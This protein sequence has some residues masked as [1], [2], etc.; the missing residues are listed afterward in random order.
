MQ[1]AVATVRKEKNHSKKD[2]ID[3][4]NMSVPLSLFI[5]YVDA[6][7]VAAHYDVERLYLEWLCSNS[8]VAQGP[9][10]KEPI[11][12]WLAAF[13]TIDPLHLRKSVPT[14]I[15][16]EIADKN[17]LTLLL[18]NDEKAVATG[19]PK[20]DLMEQ[21]KDDIIQVQILLYDCV[22]KLPAAKVCV[23]LGWQERWGYTDCW[24]NVALRVGTTDRSALV[25]DDDLQVLYIGRWMRQQHRSLMNIQI[26]NWTDLKC[27]NI[28]SRTAESGRST[29][30][31]TLRANE[32]N[33]SNSAIQVNEL[34]HSNSAIR[35]NELTHS[36]SAIRAKELT[37]LN[38]TVR[39]KGSNESRGSEIRSQSSERIILSSHSAAVKSVPARKEISSLHIHNEDDKLR[40]SLHEIA[41]RV[42]NKAMALC[43]H[44]ANKSELLQELRLLHF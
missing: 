6:I 17:S 29:Q 19:R 11:Q 42:K 16:K 31:T 22:S 18:K 1:N 21:R 7:E 9:L 26:K 3:V 37:H 13:E 25:E 43:D 12:P 10:L 40:C 38:S 27:E 14:N 44:T 28:S 32:F 5:L 41:D 39:A 30:V 2:I 20:V 34:T 15:Q 33:Y 35:A 4:D 23:R 8:W 36:N 24:H